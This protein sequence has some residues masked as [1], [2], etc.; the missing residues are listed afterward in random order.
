MNSEMNSGIKSEI[1]STS[2]SEINSLLRSFLFVPALKTQY[3]A[4]A[5]ALKPD[6]AVVD[7]EASVP[8]HQKEQALNTLPE[9][10]A[11]FKAAKQRVYVR[12][13]RER[14]Q[15][16][17]VAVMEGANGII[18]P[19]AETEAQITRAID[20]IADS[21]ISAG[22][23]PEDIA[24]M[25]LVETPLGIVNLQRIIAHHKKLA[26]IF[27][28]AEDFVQQ[29]GRGVEP[30]TT[31]LFNGAWQVSVTASAYGLP[32]YG[33][34]GSIANFQDEQGFRDLCQQAKAIGLL[35]CPVIHPRQL[36]IVEEV[37]SPSDSEIASAN[38]VIEA[39]EAAD[40]STIALK[41]R[42]IDYPIYYRAKALVAFAADS[43]NKKAGVS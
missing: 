43:N 22:R 30:T 16:Y 4:K 33:L 13:N 10:I 39:F 9:S 20:L 40:F 6:V 29:L 26:G 21:A 11:A 7:L 3:V 15:D 23:K 36:A 27:F 2:N 25:P 17:T 34:C 5:I 28:G 31:A 41:G 35:G 18:F 24:L 32:A 8:E 14:L 37:F 42:M 1:D 38:E 12:V 19:C